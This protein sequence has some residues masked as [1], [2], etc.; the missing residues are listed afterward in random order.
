MRTDCRV[1]RE[2]KTW[3]YNSHRAPTRTA[4]MLR[5]AL[6]LTLVT[7]ASAAFEAV[8]NCTVLAKDN[9]CNAVTASAL[10]A[11]TSTF[12]TSLVAPAKDNNC[13][14]DGT[15]KKCN[16]QGGGMDLKHTEWM[17]A[18]QKA[19]YAG[20][21]TTDT[22]AK[23]TALTG[24]YWIAKGGDD[25]AAGSSCGYP[26]AGLEA[27]AN[28]KSATAVQIAYLRASFMEDVCTVVSKDK[29]T[30]NA[31]ARCTWNFDGKCVPSMNAQI[32]NLVEGS[33]NTEADTLAKTLGTT[34]AAATAAVGSGAAGFS[35]FAV[36]VSALVAALSLIA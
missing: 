13:L 25:T 27:T 14:Y 22:K 2:K 26:L 32:N 15:D 7:G 28:G 17:T 20:D 12:C 23:C 3:K 9:S 24:C 10:A 5:I 36:V 29:A 19:C 31:D 34:T 30:C 33:C 11:S 4:D 8:V 1:E 18:E 35:S 6:F 21:S 16:Y